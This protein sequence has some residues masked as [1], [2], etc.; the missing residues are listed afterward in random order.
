MSCKGIFFRSRTAPFQSRICRN[1]DSRAFTRPF[2]S[3]QNS[4]AVLRGKSRRGSNQKYAVLQFLAHWQDWRF[5]N[6]QVGSNDANSGRVYGWFDIKFDKGVLNAT[7]PMIYTEHG[8]CSKMDFKC[9]R[10]E[11]SSS[12]NFASFASIDQ[13]KVIFVLFA[14][15]RVAVDGYGLPTEME[16][17]ARM[18]VSN[19]NE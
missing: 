16:R 15:E 12:V 5:R 4:T 13:F 19:A 14:T 3:T 18:E 8:Y 11:V 10:M 17:T 1:R 2:I 9:T 7:V 6:T